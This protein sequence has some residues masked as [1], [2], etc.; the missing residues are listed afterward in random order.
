MAEVNDLNNCT[1]TCQKNMWAANS[2]NLVKEMQGGKP[3][4]FVTAMDV[5]GE[6]QRP[7]ADTVAFKIELPALGRQSHRNNDFHLASLG[8][9][10]CEDLTIAVRLGLGDLN[11]KV[12]IRCAQ[13][14]YCVA[15]ESEDCIADCITEGTIVRMSI[16]ELLGRGRAGKAVAVNL[17]TYENVIDFVDLTPSSPYASGLRSDTRDVNQNT[18]LS[19][20]AAKRYTGIVKYLISQ[21]ADVNFGAP[22]CAAAAHA[23]GIVGTLLEAK[24]HVNAACQEKYYGD[25]VPSTPLIAAALYGHASAAQE[26]LK[27]NANPNAQLVGHKDESALHLAV[28]YS[29]GK[30]IVKLLLKAKAK[31]D[32]RDY[33]SRTPLHDA[34]SRCQPEIVKVLLAAKADVNARERDGET[35]LQLAYDHST[36]CDENQ[37]VMNILEA[38]GGT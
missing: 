37:A 15:Q 32:L 23:P 13:C 29:E 21:K 1:W 20:L 10:S 14:E 5:L 12:T 7:F 33:W 6:V 27:A 3:V 19:A 16:Y 36:Y 9:S 25:T 28:H 34:A 18:L 8:K 30:E 11:N 4:Y 24:A 22:L 17:T 38:A 31:V 2:E 26:L 35:P